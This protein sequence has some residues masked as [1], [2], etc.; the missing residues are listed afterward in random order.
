MK[1][2]AMTSEYTPF[3]RRLSYHL[4][5]REYSQQGFVNRLKAAGYPHSVTQ[6][7]VSNWLRLP[8]RRLY[9][10]WFHY[11][12]GVL[13]LSD[14]EVAELLWLYYTSSTK[15]R[16]ASPRNPDNISIAR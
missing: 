8:G 9:P 14:D 13:R 15:N 16:S 3:G 12:R 5:R 2:R 7:E 6:Q 4:E 1:G 10:D 11:T